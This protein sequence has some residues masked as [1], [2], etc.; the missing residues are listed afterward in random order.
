MSSN[1]LLLRAPS[2]DGPAPDKYEASFSA[3]GYRPI[4]IPVLET[5]LVNLSHL[6]EVIREGPQMR[7]LGGVIVTS[8]R[9]CEA[10]RAVVEELARESITDTNW[11]DTPFYVVGEATAAA[12]VAIRQEIPS[13]NNLAPRDIRGSAEGGTSEKL[14]HFILKDLP[15]GRNSTL[16]YLTGDKNRDLLPNILKDGGVELRSLQ[17]YGTTG[18]SRFPEDL[19]DALQASPPVAKWWIVYFA[20]SAADFVTPTLRKHFTLSASNGKALCDAPHAHLAAIGP[21][22]SAFLRDNL[23]L[24]VDVIS[25]KPTP[26]ALAEAI[27]RFDSS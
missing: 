19:E 7:G 10:W 9:A 12:L 1:V 26:E 20:P 8:A 23:N 11:S 27:Q 5:V 15:S 3:L 2:R 21:T 16:L 17:V 6:R 13:S 18:T 22:T 14:A 4:S 24:V 25:P